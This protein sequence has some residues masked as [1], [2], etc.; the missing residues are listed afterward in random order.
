[1]VPFRPRI[2]KSALFQICSHAMTQSQIPLGGEMQDQK[3]LSHLAVIIV[4]L[5]ISTE[6]KGDR[7]LQRCSPVIGRDDPRGPAKNQA[8]V[9][10]KKYLEL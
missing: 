7:C 9:K 3:P 1:M 2:Q 8:K 10:T 6:A 4:P 5:V